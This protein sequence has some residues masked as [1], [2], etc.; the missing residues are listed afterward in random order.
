VEPLDIERAFFN[1][2]L[3]LDISGEELSENERAFAL[4]DL[5]GDGT[6][7]YEYYYWQIGIGAADLPAAAQHI[8]APECADLFAQA[9]ALFPS[10]QIQA[11][12]H[13][14]GGGT[15]GYLD[16]HRVDFDAIEA[17]FRSLNDS[18]RGIRSVLARFAQ[19]HTDEFPELGEGPK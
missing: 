9:N 10:D 7:L 14:P 13:A 17:E 1:I 3:R 19:R 12:P 5:V 8:G 18:G 15:S 4:L 16:N 11:A 2:G 6:D